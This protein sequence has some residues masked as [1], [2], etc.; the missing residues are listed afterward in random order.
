[1]TGLIQEGSRVAGALVLMYENAA[2]ASSRAAAMIA[3]AIEEPRRRRGAGGRRPCDWF[4]TDSSLFRAGGVQ[5]LGQLS[6]KDVTTYNLDEYY[7]I[8]PVSSLSYHT[9][10]DDKLF[11]EI[12]DLGERTHIPDGTVPEEFVD[13]YAS[14]YDRWIEADGGL[15]LQLL[16]IGRNGH[17]GFN[18]PTDLSVPEALALPTRLVELH[19]TTIADAA[20]EFGSPEAVIPRAITMGIKTIPLRAVDRDAGNRRDQG[21]GRKAGALEPMTAQLP[22]SLLQSAG[23]RVTWIIDRAAALG[24]G[25]ALDLKGSV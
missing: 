8:S 17:I 19:E 9:Y 5:S 24:L 7:P 13:E 3:A 10:M 16:G 18:E 25:P 23:E 2:D 22:A 1:M 6:F 4:D 11:W 12:L 14:Q 21:R 20:R 15:D